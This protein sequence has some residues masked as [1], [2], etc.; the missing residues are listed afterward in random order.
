MKKLP[1]GKEMEIYCPE[2]GSGTK[3]V[4]RTNRKQDHQFLG[5]PNWPECN[6]TQS[7]PESVRMR[8][9]GQQSLFDNL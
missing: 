4:V 9:A 2:C 7:I 6:H 8:L 1:D 3:L 5:C